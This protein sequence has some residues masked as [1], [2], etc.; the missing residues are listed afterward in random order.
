MQ[1][2]HEHPGSRYVHRSAG[3][4]RFGAVP[5]AAKATAALPG[6]A[7]VVLHADPWIRDGRV[8]CGLETDL[9]DHLFRK[10][11]HLDAGT[12]LVVA[13]RPSQLDRARRLLEHAL[14]GPSDALLDRKGIDP[15]A[16]WRAWQERMRIPARD[17]DRALRLDDFVELVA[18]EGPTEIAGAT[19][20]EI[21][22]DVY[23]MHD[24]GSPELTI[25]LSSE[26]PG[27][28]LF[29]I[30]ERRGSLDGSRLAMHTL[31]CYAG[32]DPAGPTTAMHIVAGN[33]PLIVDGMSGLLPVLRA[34]GP[35][36]E[37]VAAFLLTH[38]HQDHLF[39]IVEAIVSLERAVPVVAAPPVYAELVDLM[40]AILAEPEDAIAARID[41]TPIEP[42]APGRP[43]SRVTIGDATLEAAWVAGPI[44]TTAFRIEVD[45]IVL[46]ISS[47]TLSSGQMRERGF[48]S[49]EIDFVRG[50]C[51]D[52]HTSVLDFGGAEGNP[53]HGRPDEWLE[54]SR[55][56]DVSVIGSH[57]SAEV[58]G[59]EMAFPGRIDV[60]AKV[61]SPR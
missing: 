10:G 12:R 8:L 25:D 17:T 11:G 53:V 14:D 33:S 54:D 61:A 59:A 43:G 55:G 52:A 9:W 35:A 60:L 45:G 34:I 41:W 29:G 20:E 46:A 21:A 23:R 3:S 51:L 4:I 48:G 49:D 36:P 15:R 27:P 5:D 58:P 40:S 37:D 19:V 42:A 44:P 38:V 1:T 56:R 32:N 7:A 6:V 39:G 26:S 16:P 47:D 2:V 30:P 50:F 57:T 18:L 28:P 22:P 13:A 31:G 24:E